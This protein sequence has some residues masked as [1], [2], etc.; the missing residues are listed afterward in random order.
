MIELNPFSH[1]LPILLSPFALAKNSAKPI[2]GLFGVLGEFRE[3]TEGGEVNES[4]A[5]T[6]KVRSSDVKFEA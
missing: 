3:T 4:G 1:L 6:V 2:K 5:S